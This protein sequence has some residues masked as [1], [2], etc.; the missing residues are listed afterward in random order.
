MSKLLFEPTEKQ[1]AFI[2]KVFDP[3]YTFISYGGSAGGGKTVVSL[4]SMVLLSRLFKK[5]RWCVIRKSLTEIKLNTLPSFWKVCPTNFV[6]TYNKS[7]FL[8]N[9]KN[10]SQIIFKGENIHDDPELQWMDGLEVNGFLLE[11]VEELNRK[12]Y[13]KCKL[14]AGR[15]I[16]NPMPPI[17]ILSTLNPAQNWV[18]DEIHDPYVKGE[19][20]PPYIYIPAKI[21]DN[22]HLPSEYRENLKYLDNITYRR[23]VD[24]DWSAFAVDNPFAYAFDEDKHVSKEPLVFDSSHEV[25]ITL[26]FNVS[27]CA[28][29][30]IQCFNEEIRVL[31]ESLE[32]TSDIYQICDQITATYPHAVFLVT[33]D[34]T[35]R[36]RS[37]ISRGNLNYFQVVQQQLGLVDTQMRQPTVNPS[38]RDSRVLLNSML[39][40]YRIQIDPDKCPSL[41][42]DLKHVEVDSQGDIIKD[43]TSDT[44]KSDYLDAFRYYLNTFHRDFIKYTDYQETENE[45]A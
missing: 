10:D 31:N 29:L 12:T 1:Q 30:A 9:F 24:G 23:F 5:S 27:P 32:T 39:Q 20:K 33:G 3:L 2:D 37:A 26:D 28:Y 15:W 14:R 16:I 41:I 42:R 7:E 36:A 43:R 22:P 8:V 6:K 21:S 19:L 44:K 13:D 25:Y 18:K 11:Q 35:G 34:A 4:A 45:A 38:V 40:N 17:K